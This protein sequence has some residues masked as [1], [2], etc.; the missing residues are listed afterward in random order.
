MAYFWPPL[1]YFLCL[2]TST[3]TLHHILHMR[4]LTLP[5]DAVATMSVALSVYLGFKANQAYDRWWEARKIWGLIVNYSRAFAREVLTFPSVAQGESVDA[6]RGWQRTVIYRHMAWVHGLRVFLRQPNGFVP[7]AGLALDRENTYDDLADFLD[8]K[9]R[10]ELAKAKN[11]PNVL[12]QTQGEAPKSGLLHGW[13]SDYQF[14]QMSQTLTEF[15]NHQGRSER[16][17]NTPL[18]RAYSNFSRVFVF[19]H[20]TLVP[21]AFIEELDW[22][23]IPLSMAINFIFLT[24]DLVGRQIEDPFENRISDIPLTTISTT[25]EE[26]L[27]EMLGDP[28]P[29]KPAAVDGVVY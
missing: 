3:F 4:W 19:V 27:K 15:N 26:N 28:L 5:F 7:L 11:P 14:V 13:L 20:G 17:K 10:A 8:E 23:N 22:M 24:L 12:L 6:L 2:S 1:L 16:I 29:S 25:I 21:F 18:P 9:E